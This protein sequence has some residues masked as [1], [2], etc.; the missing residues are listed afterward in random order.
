MDRVYVE[1]G[2][3]EMRKDGECWF[4]SVM[5]DREVQSEKFVSGDDDG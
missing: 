4:S 3:K 2:K 5:S 1:D